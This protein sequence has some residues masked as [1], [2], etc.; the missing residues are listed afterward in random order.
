M[1]NKRSAS[2]HLTQSKELFDVIVLIKSTTFATQF[3]T[4]SLLSQPT[5][6]YRRID[7]Y[8]WVCLLLIPPIVCLSNEDMHAWFTFFCSLRMI[9]IRF[10]TMERWRVEMREKTPSS[11]IWVACCCKNTFFT[12]LVIRKPNIHTQA[13]I[14]LHPLWKKQHVC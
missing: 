12:L 14:Q 6:I 5:F 9:S 13:S 1:Q 10:A 3:A 8:N 2:R 4:F 7:N 11:L